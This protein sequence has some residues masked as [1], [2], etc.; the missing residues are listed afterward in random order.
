MDVKSA[1]LNGVTQEEVFVR[2]PTGFENPEYPNRLYK[3]S[4]FCTGLS[5]RRGHGMLGL[6]HFC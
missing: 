2:Q 6:R 5:K 1:F 3:L 4:K